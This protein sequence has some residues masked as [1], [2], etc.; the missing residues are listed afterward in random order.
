MKNGR[1]N[2]Q[3]A[4]TA[5]VFQPVPA[6]GFPREVSPRP[7]MRKLSF[8]L[9]A[10]LTLAWLLAGCATSTLPARIQEKS[11]AY[12]ALTP[13]Q[14]KNVES[15]TIE[16]GYTTDMVYLALGSPRQVQ[17]KD[18]PEGKA[19]MWS[20]TNFDATGPVST[21][22][23]NSPGS[24]STMMQTLP[25]ASGRGGSPR[26]ATSGGPTPTLDLADIPSQTLYVFFFDGKVF[27]IKIDQPN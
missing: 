14:R 27:E 17:T 21:L 19:E 11:A 24:R 6:Y 10:S 16:V 15:G 25:S 7:P 4:T 18:T 23:F 12:A 8:S 2:S 1:D 13:E 22:S 9:G 3:G 20:Y 26:T 5:P